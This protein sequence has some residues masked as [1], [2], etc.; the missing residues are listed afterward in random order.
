M[1]YGR[2]RQ[3]SSLALRQRD[4]RWIAAALLALSIPASVDAQEAALD[5]LPVRPINFDVAIR[6]QSFAPNDREIGVQIGYTAL[7]YGNLEV[8]HIYQFFSI[9]TEGDKTDQHST[10]LNPRWNNFIDILDFPRAMPINRVI[11][12]VLFGPLE[13]RAIPYVGA[14]GGMVLPGPGDRPGQLY[15]GQVGVRF[16]VAQGIAVDFSMQYTEFKVEFRGQ[17]GLAQ[18]WIFLSGVRF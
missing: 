12:H 1:T 9:H 13:D 17:G 14:I 18:Q 10:F 11:R 15:G 8:R 2:L 6:Q 3:R 16:P 4:T 5:L 7:R